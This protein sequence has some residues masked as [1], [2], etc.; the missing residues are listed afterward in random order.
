VRLTLDRSLPNLEVSGFGIRGSGLSLEF[1]FRG[2][3]VR[4]FGVRGSGF[5]VRDS[6][7]G[8]E[9]GFRVCGFGVRGV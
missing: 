8:F 7:L 5:V 6:G 3:G 1:G 4:G 2:F 9:V